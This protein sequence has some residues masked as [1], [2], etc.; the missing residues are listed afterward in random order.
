MKTRAQTRGSAFIPFTEYKKGKGLCPNQ[1]VQSQFSFEQANS[2]CD[3]HLHFI[4]QA[5]PQ[6]CQASTSWQNPLPNAIV[7]SLTP[8][9]LSKTSDEKLRLE[10]KRKS[11]AQ[12]KRR[13][14]TLASEQARQKERKRDAERKRQ[15]RALIHS[16]LGPDEL[17]VKREKDAQRM[18]EKRAQASS[19]IKKK[20]RIQDAERKRAKRQNVKDPSAHS[21]SSQ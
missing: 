8:E 15:K 1:E 4:I 7:L 20:V 14:R 13:Q 19:D 5:K 16:Q 9:E 17:K 18:R 10:K 6:V 2:F 11:D 21:E 3:T 12:R